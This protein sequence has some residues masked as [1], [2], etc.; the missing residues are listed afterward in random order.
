M[1]DSL[2]AKMGDLATAKDD[3][4]NFDKAVKA[5]DEARKNYTR[6]SKTNT[7]KL[8]IM[9]KSLRKCQELLDRKETLEKGYEQQTAMLE[10]KKR[11]LRKLERK[12]AQIAEQIREQ[13]KRE[14]SLGAYRA[15]KQELKKHGEEME[16]LDSFFA[17]RKADPGG[18]GT[19]GRAG[20]AENH[21]GKSASGKEKASS[22]AGNSGADG[23]FICFRSAGGNGDGSV[24]TPG[25]AAQ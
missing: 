1:T 19:D 9:K 15:K 23:D 3:I 14:Q 18:A 21:F 7:G 13:S 24:E 25:R 6:R 12:K 11:Q 16:E 22:A 2:N 20:A 5:I 17:R 10:E 8:E 4:N